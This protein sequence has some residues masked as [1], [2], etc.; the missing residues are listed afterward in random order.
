MNE[1]CEC[2]RILNVYGVNERF[3]PGCGFYTYEHNVVT[4]KLESSRKLVGGSQP[5]LF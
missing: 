2:G 1:K 4:P 3:C 5:T